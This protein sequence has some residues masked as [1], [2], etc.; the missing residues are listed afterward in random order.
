MLI[1]YCWRLQPA[2]HHPNEAIEGHDTGRPKVLARAEAG[3]SGKTC[4]VGSTPF[5]E[6]ALY[7]F[8]ADHPEA[9]NAAIDIGYDRP[10]GYK[11]RAGIAVGY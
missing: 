3:N 6:S 10:P 8:A 5:P 2:A 1:R 7:V 9:R 11:L 4:L